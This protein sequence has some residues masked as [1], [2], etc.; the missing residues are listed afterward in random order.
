MNPTTP[1]SFINP[2]PA[3]QGSSSVIPCS[4]TPNTSMWQ[5]AH[6]S[7][8]GGNPGSNQPHH[9]ETTATAPSSANYSSPYPPTSA[10]T[11]IIDTKNTSVPRSAG[12]TNV[13]ASSE[14]TPTAL[15]ALQQQ[16]IVA[17]QA[18]IAA[19]AETIRA[20]RESSTTVASPTVPT[21]EG[22]TCPP[23]VT[24]AISSHYAVDPDYIRKIYENTFRP[25]QLPKLH[26]RGRANR[27]FDD[28]I[29]VTKSSEIRAGSSSSSAK[30]FGE[31]STIWR[32]S[33]ATYT[34]ILATL[35]S[36]EFPGLTSALIKFSTTINDLAGSYNWSAVLA[37]ALEHHQAVLYSPGGV[38]GLPAWSIPHLRVTTMLPYTEQK[39]YIHSNPRK[40]PITS[41]A[42]DEICRNFNKTR[43]CK[44]GSECRYRHEKIR[45]IEAPKN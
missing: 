45:N 33:F 21:N 7:G 26:P 22:K 35:K 30:D 42:S 32:E 17:H 11:D 38:T 41:E 28:S 29:H 36:A 24:S 6:A 18:T 37:L 13:S 14:G 23:R 34:A 5:G 31:N 20:L 40:R 19:Q 43:G 2:T 16:L 10:T 8:A 9:L 15:E 1:A 12:Q 3:S 4:Q 39:G 44:K 27:V 25:T